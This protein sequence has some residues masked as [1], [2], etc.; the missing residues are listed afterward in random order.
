MSE[1]CEEFGSDKALEIAKTHVEKYFAVVG[2]MERWQ[3]SLK[4]F[5]NYIPAYF[6]D[7]RKIYNGRYKRNKDNINK[8]N[9][10]YYVPE[11]IKNVIAKNFTK[12]LEFYDFC[13]QRFQK[14]LLAIQ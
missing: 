10:K 13:K 3:E 4:L 9:F 14:Q 1:D 2:I 5:E 7:A 8:N 6:K 12:E 11:Y